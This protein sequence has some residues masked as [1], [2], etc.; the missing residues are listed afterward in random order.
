MNFSTIFFDCYIKLILFC[1]LNLLKVNVKKID[2]GN[3]IRLILFQKTLLLFSLYSCTNSVDDSSVVIDISNKH[4]VQIGNQVWLTKNLDVSTFQN[5]D[6]IFHAKSNEEWV[7]A[8]Q[9]RQP[10]WCYYNNDSLNCA[11]YGKLYNWY[12]VND[13]RGI[14]PKGFHIPDEK[15]WE[16]LSKFYNHH[17]KPSPSEKLNY[18]D[19]WDEN[20]NGTNE[21][22]FSGL[23]GGQRDRNG[24]FRGVGDWS[25]Y[26][27]ARNYNGQSGSVFGIGGSQWPNE[28]IFSKSQGA[29]I[30]CIKN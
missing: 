12:A 28:A 16:T 17:E 25:N 7:R 24:V 10:A 4:E 26:W 11:K 15:E 21:S 29:S 22:G 5:G 23:P 3:Y 19:H 27:T 20:Q 18:W 13:S 9:N 1:G 2:M 6:L 30:R 14:A 8:G